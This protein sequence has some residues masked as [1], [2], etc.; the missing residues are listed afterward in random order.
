[1]STYSACGR[2]TWS[3]NAGAVLA[4]ADP[5]VAV[6]SQAP[7]VGGR[8]AAEQR[9]IAAPL[10]PVRRAAASRRRQVRAPTH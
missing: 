6:A 1:M 4:L 5:S 2:P 7:R 10:H 9:A 3:G 8:V